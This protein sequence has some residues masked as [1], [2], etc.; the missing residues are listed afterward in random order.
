METLA[1]LPNKSP[2]IIDIFVDAFPFIELQVVVQD[3]SRVLPFLEPN[4][5][6]AK[7]AP[8]RFEPHLIRLGS[9]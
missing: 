8:L 9:P 6:R 4:T 3:S 7:H 1:Y 5:V 2:V